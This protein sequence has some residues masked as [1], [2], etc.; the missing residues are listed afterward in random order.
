MSLILDLL[1]PSRCYSCGKIGKYFC[2]KCTKDIFP[3]SLD[4]S[5]NRLS[6]FKYNDVIRKAITDLKY[7]FVTDI[8]DE[9]TDI[10][11]KSI[12]SN[13]PHLLKYWQKNKFIIIPIPLHWTR[14]NWRSFNQS[15]LLAKNIAKKIKLNYIPNLLTKTKNTASQAS[16]LHKISRTKNLNHAFTHN[17]NITIPKN[18]IIFDDVYTT[19]A[20]LNSAA[21]ILKSNCH[22]IWFL[23]LAG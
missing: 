20:T 7:G 17:P 23:T 3:L 1:F 11:A 9:L 18:I 15:D 21:S 2:K 5:G 16:F 13:Y 19:G 8:I 22:E 4:P 14:R 10:S 6:L 12:K